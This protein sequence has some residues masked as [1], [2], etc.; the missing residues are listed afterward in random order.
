VSAQKTHRLVTR[1]KTWCGLLTPSGFTVILAPPNT[2]PT[3]LSCLR[4]IKADAA[5]WER[6]RWGS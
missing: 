6:H 5:V 2:E 3:C 4:A 1:I